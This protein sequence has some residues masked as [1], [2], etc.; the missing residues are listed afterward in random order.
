MRYVEFKI[1]REVGVILC[2]DLQLGEKFYPKGHTINAEDIIIFKM[3][4]LSSIFGA[5]FEEGDVDYKIALKQVAAQISGRGIGYLIEKNGI[6]SIIA[7]QDGVFVAEDNRIDKFNRFN[8]HIILNTIPPYSVVKKGDLIA[9]LD[10]S[11]PLVNETEID[12]IIFRLSGNSH[13]LKVENIKEKKSVLLYP[14]LLND[15]NENRHFTSVVMKLITNLDGLGVSF[16]KEISA[17][18]NQDNLEDSLFG[19]FSYGADIIF[20]LSPIKTSG[21][22]DVIAKALSKSVDD[23]VNYS[24]P[25]VNASDFL[26][27]QK[28]NCKIIILPC[29]YDIVDTT[30]IDNLIKTAIF[31]E[32]LNVALFNH[33]HSKQLFSNTNFDEAAQNKMIMPSKKALSSQKASVGIVVLA[34]GQGRRSG[35]SKLL[36]EDETGSPLFM[37]AVNAAIASDAKPVFVVIGH[38]NEEMEEYLEKLDVNVLYNPSFA[39][40]VKTSINLGLKSIPSSCDGAILL[41]ADMPN[42]TASDINKLINKFDKNQEKQVCLLANKGIKSNPILWSRSLYDRA[43]IVPE[44]SHLR[45]VFVEHAD[46]TNIVEIRD[47]KKLLDINF[48]NDVKEFSNR[49]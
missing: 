34:A 35:S 13:L 12:D 15:E 36:V 33:K 49:H 2:S 19:A 40:G 20:V 44:N 17:N 21:R 38:R 14:H 30:L 3:F 23:I 5:V 22:G 28:G 29:S 41:P 45:A 24:M 32:H 47:K 6:C 1:N 18:Y 4:N 27:A 10:I 7:A 48:P 37:Y 9:E 8:E 42:I 31:T 43:D 25:Q 39:S 16:T 46:Y 26:I 11:V